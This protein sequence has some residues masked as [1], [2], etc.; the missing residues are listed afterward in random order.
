M[1]SV[2]GRFK[3]PSTIA[4]CRVPL[5]ALAL[6][7]MI[8]GCGG[9]GGGSRTPIPPSPTTVAIVLDSQ[10]LAGG[11]V[12]VSLDG[13][14]EVS[15]DAEGTRTLADSIAAGSSYELVITNQPLSLSCTLG[16]ASGDVGEV[17][18]TVT[19]GCS[20]A[21]SFTLGGIA[22]GLSATQTVTL[23]LS[24]TESLQVTGDGAYR[25]TTTLF[26]TESYAV[27]VTEEPPFLDCSLANSNATVSAGNVAN[28][29]LTCAS[30]IPTPQLVVDVN[31]T[32]VNNSSNPS[33][34][35]TFGGLTLFAAQDGDSL[36]VTDG[37][38]A[39][40]TQLLGSDVRPGADVKFVELDGKAYFIAESPADEYRLWVTNG[41]AAGTQQVSDALAI[42]ASPLLLAGNKLVFVAQDPVSGIEPWVSD[43]TAAGT[44]LLTEIIPGANSVASLLSSFNDLSANLAAD[45]RLVFVG[46]E[47]DT[48]SNI[49]VW[50][51][52]G[53]P[54]GT[55]KLTDLNV[56]ASA[57]TLSSMVAY[58]GEVYFTV[59]AQFGA[60]REELWATGGAVADTRMIA[61]FDTSNGSSIGNL[62]AASSELYFV[63]SHPSDGVEVW[64]SDGTL[65]N[66]R[67]LDV[68]AGAASTFARGFVDVGTAVL[69][70]TQGGDGVWATDG[71][72][73]GTQLVPGLAAGTFVTKVLPWSFANSYWFLAQNDASGQ[74]LWRAT[75]TQVELFHEFAPGS[76]TGI[77][78]LSNQSADPARLYLAGLDPITGLEPY[79]VPNTLAAPTLLANLVPENQTAD[80]GATIYGET[81]S[82]LYF[83]GCNDALGCEPWFTNGTSVG[84]SVSE[85]EV[86]PGTSITGLGAIL[87]NKLLVSEDNSLEL[88]Q[89]DAPNSLVESLGSVRIGNNAQQDGLV[90]FASEPFGFV[91]EPY[92][93]DGTAAGTLPL[94]SIVGALPVAGVTV[95]TPFE[96]DFVFIGSSI[97]TGASTL[98]R[99]NRG[100][101]TVVELDA[102]EVGLSVDDKLTVLDGK[103][104]FTHAV[105]GEGTELYSSDGTPGSLSLVKDIYPG[106]DDGASGGRVLTT[107][108]T[109]I[110]F[111]GCTA[112]EGC[113]LW[114]S[115]G[116]EA[117]T[118]LVKDLQI[119]SASASFVS[120]FVVVDDLAYFLA[121]IAGVRSIWVTDGT[122][123]G[124]QR[125]TP[126][127]QSLAGAHGLTFYDEQF[128]FFAED[129]EGEDR[130]WVFDGIS[131]VALIESLVEVSDFLGMFVAENEPHSGLYVV[132]DD[133]VVG[134]E[135]HRLKN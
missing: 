5:G 47:A 49:D 27:S 12:G 125:L 73:A 29:A 4:L 46:R 85:T 77:Q 8:S 91:G 117:G 121:S 135:L 35:F 62:Y 55:S 34:F 6:A 40:T 14:A 86:G 18:V 24:G 10:G 103:L 70:T 126:E 122:E 99:Y 3:N 52:D 94:A 13:G 65:A 66:T 80:G 113:E 25:F 20:P 68:R 58:G 39:G 87:D 105:A 59:T 127:S 112:A 109:G 37:T 28:L 11:S 111:L 88:Y 98:V 82:G 81:D 56:P 41:T 83:M 120:D 30:T 102:V 129:T 9:G 69:F 132:G 45:N 50:V 96:Q 107:L 78:Q 16:N 61:S 134:R 7:L 124:T 93:T 22:D 26:D 51:T 89:I 97:A 67:H 131:S 17:D 57:I 48:N 79:W 92:V 31:Q 95:I 104:L 116:T 60:L 110:L 115:D 75:P 19:L 21:Q 63:A 32:F 106:P 118:Q 130:L 38:S 76:G 44:S 36:W 119:G 123:Q 128:Y 100:L 74:E 1:Q 108:N 53:T 33:R 84:T 133:G 42:Y 101:G 43:G 71:S 114:R 64:V 23:S 2:N 15:I 90:F 72:S 54:A